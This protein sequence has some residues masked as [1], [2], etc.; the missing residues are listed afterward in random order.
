MEIKKLPKNL[1]DALNAPLPPEAVA[2]H[3]T[4]KYLSTIKAIYVV[5]R[6]NE[7][8]GVGGWHQKNTPLTSPG[9]MKQVHSTLEIPEYGIYLDNFGGNDN[10][11]E[12]DAWKG[13]ATDALTKMASYLGIGMDVFKG[14]ATPSEAPQ[15][16]LN[17]PQ[18]TKAPETSITIP[19]CVHGVLKRLQVKKAGANQ[20]KYFYACP[21]KQGEQCENVFVWEEELLNPVEPHEV[22]DETMRKV[23]H[24]DDGWQ[25]DNEME[26]ER[27]NVN[28]ELQREADN[29]NRPEIL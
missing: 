4:K 18:S 8:F 3:P 17:A 27:E 1:V 20:G 15:E 6:L 24:D 22:I 26:R 19:Q 29:E 10:V 11:D 13:A 28:A 14:L 9:P 21:A 12:G 23:R 16:R 7:V 2:Q 5:E 25:Q